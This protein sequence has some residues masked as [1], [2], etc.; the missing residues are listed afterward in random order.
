[1]TCN[2]CD[3]TMQCVSI[4]MFWCPRCGT[5]KNE[6]IFTPMLVKRCRDFETDPLLP[7]LL[8]GG[9]VFQVWRRLGIVESIH[10]PSE[11]SA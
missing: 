10:V 8:L 5:I 7:L 3:H 4:G 2:N 1:M 6:M 11:R 9:E